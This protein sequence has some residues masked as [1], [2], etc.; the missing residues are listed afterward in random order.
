VAFIC[1]GASELE[2]SGTTFLVNFPKEHKGASMKNKERFKD[3]RK[4]SE[5]L[6]N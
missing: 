1:E 2:I 5:V 6:E 3:I 4:A